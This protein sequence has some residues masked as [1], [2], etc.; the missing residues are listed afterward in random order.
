[1]IGSFY[2]HRRTSKTK[3]QSAPRALTNARRQFGVRGDV[4]ARLEL[5]L[6]APN[7]DGLRPAQVKPILNLSNAFSCF[8]GVA[9]RHDHLSEEKKQQVIALGKLG[10]PLRRIEQATGVRRET[11]S[12]Y[13]KSAGIA[14]RPPRGWGR[15]PIP[16]PANE[17][18]TDSPAGSTP[19]PAN[20]VSTDP[21]PAWPPR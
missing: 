18:S 11:A 9:Q 14:I 8:A 7:I 15:R 13:L 17:T 3:K 1:M 5:G 20:E 21:P 19:K 4:Q 12:A 16:K 6:P 10:W 2:L